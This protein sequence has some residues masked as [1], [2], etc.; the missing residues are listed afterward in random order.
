MV[1][2]AVSPEGER[3][4]AAAR[5]PADAALIAGARPGRDGRKVLTLDFEKR[6]IA[7]SQLFELAP[8]V[9][10]LGPAELREQ[11]ARVARGLSCYAVT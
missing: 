2:L 7:V 3:A 10:V 4:L 6:R 9:E 11:L 5:P 1:E 8:A